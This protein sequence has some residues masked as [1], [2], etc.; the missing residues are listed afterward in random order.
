MANSTKPSKPSE[1]YPLFAHN[2]GSWAKKI[3]GK[4]HYFG[5]WSDPQAALDRYLEQKDD[6]HAGRT[7]RTKGDGLTVRDLCNRFMT[8]KKHKLGTGEIVQRSFADC[9]SAC[10]RLVEFFG[11]NRL[12]KAHA[13]RYRETLRFVR[14]KE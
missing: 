2:N 6:L 5:P 14:S 10:K 9:H 12:V 3:R 13:F 11:K 7:P 8:S 1:A 4:L